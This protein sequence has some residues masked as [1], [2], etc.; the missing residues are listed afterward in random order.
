MN[1]KLSRFMWW[2]KLC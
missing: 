2:T 1:R